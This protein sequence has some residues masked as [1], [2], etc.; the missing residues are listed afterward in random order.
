ML[1]RSLPPLATLLLASAAAVVLTTLGACG[2]NPDAAAALKLAAPSSMSSVSDAP[3]V[4]S[5]R[6][7]QFDD[8][9]N[10]VASDPHPQPVDGGAQTH[11]DDHADVAQ[12]RQLAQALGVQVM[13]IDLE[14]CD[15]HALD[16]IVG[17][18]WGLQAAHGLPAGTPVLLRSTDLDMAAAV[19]ERLASGGLI[20]VWVVT[21]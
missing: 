2:G 14:C 17:L 19:A 9:G 7:L 10:F 13:E 12:A 21:P 5:V 20:N 4:A 8:D 15:S 6:P 11:A 16:R 18:V 1:N 3:A